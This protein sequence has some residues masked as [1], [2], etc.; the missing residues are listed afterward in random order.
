[1][2]WSRGQAVDPSGIGPRLGFAAERL[3]DL[4]KSF[5]LK[6]LFIYYQ[7][8]KR[9]RVTIIQ[10][11]VWPF[12]SW[13]STGVGVGWCQIWRTN[14]QEERGHYESDYSKMFLNVRK[15]NH[16]LKRASGSHESLNSLCFSFFTG[17]WG[18]IRRQWNKGHFIP[19]S[20]AAS[21]A[22]VEIIIIVIIIN[23]PSRSM[24]ILG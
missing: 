3:C 12:M 21:F 23:S 11:S 10:Y 8:P 24:W 22:I 2:S 4:G 19:S 17:D 18:I 20:V 5:N 15:I 13:D 7:Q 6:K 1:M 14:S 9:K 16:Q